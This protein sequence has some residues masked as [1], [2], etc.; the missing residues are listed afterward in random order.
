MND[1]PNKNSKRISMKDTMKFDK[2]ISDPIDAP[3]YETDFNFNDQENAS[4]L[5]NYN[6]NIETL[7]E[8]YSSLKPI[9]DVI[10]RVFVKELE[11][12]EGGLYKPHMQTVMIPTQSGIGH[13]EE[14]E[15]P[16][17]Y[18]RKAIIVAAPKSLQEEN[19]YRTSLAA[20]TIVILANNPVQ[21]RPM[22]G[23]R[24]A[25]LS[26]PKAFTHPDLV[27]SDMIP[28]EADNRHYGYLL[29]SPMDIKIIM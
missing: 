26:I 3:N 20:G 13:L 11:Q 22:G 15:S 10:V 29:V 5:V 24:D 8:A 6:A 14:V 12:T 7:D 16:W 2:N 9:S 4:K 23:G 17:A 1:K 18:S 28:T 27:A 19:Q 25:A 21:S